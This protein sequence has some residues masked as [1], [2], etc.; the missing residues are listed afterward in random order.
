MFEKPLLTV[1]IATLHRPVYLEEAVRSVVEAAR[2]TSAVIEMIVSDMGCATASKFAYD[3]AVQNAPPNLRVR[4]L[5]RPMVMTGIENWN[6]CLREATGL[7]YMMIGDDD[8]LRPDAFYIL[9]PILIAAPNSTAAV[10][11]S[12]RDINAHGKVSHQTRNREAVLVGRAFLERV[13]LRRITLR[14]CAFVARTEVL[15]RTEPFSLPFPGGGG[16]ADGAAI[17][18]ASMH[19]AVQ[20]LSVAISEFRVHG[21]NDSR[22]IDINYQIE[23]RNVLI[24]FLG[25]QALLPRW[26]ENLTNLWLGTGVYFQIMRWTAAHELDIETRD[27]LRKLAKNYVDRVSFRE[28][29]IRFL[30]FSKFV[31]FAS[32][33][34]NFLYY[35]RLNRIAR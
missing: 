31:V 27:A 30:L 23:Q 22:G 3:R 10:L 34:S 9:S 8:R 15:H 2:H 21:A 13:V 28:L 32:N 25:Q 29:P 4:R 35:R 33:I 16:A 5:E 26:V 11:A 20:T 6:Q 18:S 12:A 19:G 7:F 17:L 1:G 14:W 24:R